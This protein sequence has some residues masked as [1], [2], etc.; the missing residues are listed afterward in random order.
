M[1]TINTVK[2]LAEADSPLLLF[3]CLVPG[4]DVQRFSTHAIT[5][6]GQDYSPRVLTHNL[7]DFQLSAD[8]AMDS[9]AQVSVTLANAD[10]LLSEIDAEFGWKGTQLTVYFVFAD[11]TSGT[12]TTESTIVFRGVAGDPDEITEDSLQLTFS[13]KLSLLRVGLP[14]TRIQRLCPWTFPA[15]PEQRAQAINGDRYSRFSMCGYSADVS[16]GLGNLNSG[17][18]FN[19]CDH[20]RAS[21]MQRGMFNTDANGKTTS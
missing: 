11:L 2:E 18:A 10:S 20:T 3:E 14:A 16:G 13:N 17:Q 8:D 5:F 9:V 19:S 21:C 4:G 7:F 15:S 6:N 12:T 1:S